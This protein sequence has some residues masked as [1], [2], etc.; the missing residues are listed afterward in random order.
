MALLGAQARQRVAAAFMREET[1]E[2]HGFTK[3]QLANAV[4]AVDQWVEDNTA[5]FNAALPAGFRNSATAAQKAALLGYVLWRR[6]GRLRVSE[7]G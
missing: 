6:I 2:P 4:N 7:D 3:P 1:S 5:S